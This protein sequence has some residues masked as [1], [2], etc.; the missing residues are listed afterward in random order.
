MGENLVMSS[1][2]VIVG[3]FSVLF[4]D[5]DLSGMFPKIKKILLFN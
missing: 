4:G 2:S 1:V 5:V 3:N